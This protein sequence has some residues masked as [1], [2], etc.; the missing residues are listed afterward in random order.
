MSKKIKQM[1][2]EGL[3]QSFQDVRDMILLT[4]SGLD[5]QME[6]QLRLGLRKK[7]IRIQRVKNSLA[8]RVFDDL[9]LKVTNVWEHPTVVAWGAGSLS[10]LSRELESILKKNDKIKVKTA[11]SEGQELPFDKALKMP[12]KGEAIGR[13]VALATSPA[14]RLV[15]QILGPASRIMGQVKSLA[16]K[17]PAT[18]PAEG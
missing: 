17:P 5:A 18:A 3:K 14:R 8:R 11:V 6:N 2:M 9:G 10:E 13:V 16:E 7:S 15:S 12:T 1:E 4:S